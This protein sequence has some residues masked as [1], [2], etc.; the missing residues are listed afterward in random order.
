M[1]PLL[2]L[3]AERGALFHLR[4]GLRSGVAGLDA[5]LDLGHVDLA[6]CVGLSQDSHRL[7]VVLA[8]AGR[9]VPRLL[10]SAVVPTEEAAPSLRCSV[11]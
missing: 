10:A 1:L 5:A 11:R 3:G 6:A 9:R 2:A 8:G 7:A 4:V